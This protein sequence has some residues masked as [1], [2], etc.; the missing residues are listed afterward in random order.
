MKSQQSYKDLKEDVE[1]DVPS[2]KSS[3]TIYRCLVYFLVIYNLGLTVIFGL[4][5]W[6]LLNHVSEQDTNIKHLQQNI[7]SL[8]GDK[9]STV[10]TMPTLSP[11]GVLDFTNNINA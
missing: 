8:V 9:S 5:S 6:F 10:M 7:Q 11:G 1:N 4:A 2:R 3:L